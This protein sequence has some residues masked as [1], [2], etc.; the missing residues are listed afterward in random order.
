MLN[1][2]LMMG[3][4]MQLL[5]CSTRRC[6]SSQTKM[7]QLCFLIRFLFL[8]PSPIPDICNNH[9]NL[10]QTAGQS[11]CQREPSTVHSRPWRARIS[12]PRTCH[13]IQ[14]HP[15]QPHIHRRCSQS[16]YQ[17]RGIIVYTH[18]NILIRLNV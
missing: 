17:P 12:F 16:H 2:W 10:L 4:I 1:Y 8:T 11:W 6:L 7:Q 14:S 5:W 18:V 3:I 9:S 15:N 13:T